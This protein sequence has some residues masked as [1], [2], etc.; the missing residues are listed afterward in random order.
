MCFLFCTV[1]NEGEYYYDTST[2]DIHFYKT[3][4]P[5]MA[6]ANK[7]MGIYPIMVLFSSFVW[8]KSDLIKTIPFFT[9]IVTAFLT[10]LFF[11][12]WVYPEQSKRVKEMPIIKLSSEKKERLAFI[13]NQQL[14]KYP[15][16][17][18]ILIL[19]F[20]FYMLF[21]LYRTEKNPTLAFLGELGL[22]L[23]APLVIIAPGFWSRKKIYKRILKREI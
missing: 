13:G 16:I 17:L 20:L 4:K 15:W 9:F 7:K 10:T 14:N 22:G 8:S 23:F 21:D 5:I 11:Y 12:F 1:E 19:I 6:K 18:I 2:D 3:L